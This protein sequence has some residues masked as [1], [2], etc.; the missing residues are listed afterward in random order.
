MINGVAKAYSSLISIGLP[1]RS[2]RQ[3]QDAQSIDREAS[4]VT[5]RVYDADGQRERSEAVF[6]TSNILSVL[7]IFGLAFCLV[8]GHEISRRTKPRTCESW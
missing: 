3:R 7:L 8:V 5:Y 4:G 2:L 6:T 1:V